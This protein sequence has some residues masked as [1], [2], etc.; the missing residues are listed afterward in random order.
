MCWTL[1]LRINFNSLIIMPEQVY[2]YP[3]GN[4]KAENIKRFFIALYKIY[5]PKYIGTID[6]YYVVIYYLGN[7]SDFE[8]KWSTYKSDVLSISYPTTFTIDTS[9]GFTEI[10]NEFTD[11]AN[12]KIAK[13]IHNSKLEMFH[14]M[15]NLGV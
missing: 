9:I 4:K 14:V 1:E 15:I 11:V 8:S 3:T 10:T 12:F 7:S 13:T 6:K 5:T 2:Y